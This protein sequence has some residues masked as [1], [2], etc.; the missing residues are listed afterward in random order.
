MKKIAEMLRSCFVPSPRSP[1]TQQTGNVVTISSERRR[2]AMMSWRCRNNV[3]TT[4]C[5]YWAVSSPHPMIAH[6]LDLPYFQ[7]SQ[8]RFSPYNFLLHVTDVLNSFMP[9][10]FFCIRRSSNNPSTS[11]GKTFFL[12]GV[13]L[14]K[15]ILSRLIITY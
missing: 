14:S 4:L 12:L 8:S 1:R 7:M 5:V 3:V 15:S 11:L 13:L 9:N 2:N 10:G 6:E